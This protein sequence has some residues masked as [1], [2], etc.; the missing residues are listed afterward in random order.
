M[1]SHIL[2]TLACFALGIGVLI[3]IH[4]FGHFW[5]ARRSHV[6]V[7]T[8]SIGFGPAL[9]RWKSRFGT[10]FVLSLIPLGGYVKMLDEAHGHVA[11]DKLRLAYNRKTP[12]V[13]IGILLGGPVA[14]LLFAVF[15]YWIVFIVGMEGL[16]PVVGPIEPASIAQQAG[17]REGDEILSVEGRTTQTWQ[18]AKT[19]FLEHL[20]S[21]RHLN[22]QVKRD[23]ELV[24]L[25]FDLKQWDY[26]LSDS[27]D[28]MSSLGMKAF[29]PVVPAVVGTIKSAG[30]ASK[31]GLQPNDVILAINGEPI[32]SWFNFVD[33]IKKSPSKTLM[34]DVNRDNQRLKLALVPDSVAVGGQEEGLANMALSTKAYES[35]IRVQRLGPLES[36][37]WAFKKTYAEASLSLSLL[38]K[39]LLGQISVN[40]LSG[41][42]GIAEGAGV[43]AT[44]GFTHYLSFLALV[45]VGLGVLNLLPIPILDGGNILLCLIEWVRGRPLS[46]LVQGVYYKVGLLL[47][48]VLMGLAV[49]ND[50]MRFVT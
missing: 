15:L 41:P 45:S 38:T 19:S 33:W 24:A 29:K 31:A 48:F 49:Y 6:R 35:L 3:F 9:F 32:E 27:K 11:P 21:A 18:A 20:G 14:N 8:F 46:L 39:M 25:N 7:E 40:Q 34:L 37:G 30:A 10:E 36:I 2:F 4:E 44:I 22:V 47:L 23:N 50:V 5:M 1:F 28:I 43:S 42:I 26:H 13:R 17:L 12:L 16:V